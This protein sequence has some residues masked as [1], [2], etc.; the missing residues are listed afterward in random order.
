MHR[1]EEIEQ[2]LEALTSLAGPAIICSPGIAIMLQLLKA[3][4]TD[5][6][7]TLDELA[8]RV[9]LTRQSLCRYLQHLTAIGVAEYVPASES[10]QSDPDIRLSADTSVEARRYF[11]EK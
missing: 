11:G 2:A 4:R 6:S 5:K 7:L 9:E 1:L 3:D 8:Q 10:G